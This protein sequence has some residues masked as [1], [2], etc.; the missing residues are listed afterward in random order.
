MP[1]GRPHAGNTSIVDLLK[2]GG[3]S[4]AAIAQ[5]TTAASQLTKH[6]LVALW[7]SNDPDSQRKLHGTGDL[8]SAPQLATTD[9]NSILLAFANAYNSQP[10]P[11]S[12]FFC[13][14]S[15]CCC[16]PCCCCA[17]AVT[18]PTQAGVRVA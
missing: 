6:H 9:I 14:W 10:A 2:S 16:T 4:Q 17:V 18:K 15:C 11:G 13:S 3:A 8:P 1:I 12:G 7:L 5:L